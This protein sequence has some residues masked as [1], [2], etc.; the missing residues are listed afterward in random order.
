MEAHTQ[1]TTV[2][3]DHVSDLSAFKYVSR[4]V[5]VCASENSGSFLEV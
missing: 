5:Q 1:N 4:A 2:Q 3:G